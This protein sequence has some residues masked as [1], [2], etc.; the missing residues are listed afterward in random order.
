MK[1]AERLY[2]MH[3]KWNSLKYLY[4]YLVVKLNTFSVVNKYFVS[5]IYLRKKYD[6]LSNNRYT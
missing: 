4:S 3:Y 1:N 2:E 6:K 5:T